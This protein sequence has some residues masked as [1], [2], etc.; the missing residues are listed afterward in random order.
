KENQTLLIFVQGI[1]GKREL[2]FGATDYTTTIDIWSGGGCVLA[3][4]LLGQGPKECSRTRA[5]QSLVRWATPQLH[6][7]DDLAKMVDPPDE[8]DR[9]LVQFVLSFEHVADSDDF[10]HFCDEIK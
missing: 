9:L 4:L 6:D 5:E 7:M 3:E 1:T 2:I 8:F 10:S